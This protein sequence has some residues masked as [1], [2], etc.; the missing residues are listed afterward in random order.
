VAF[1]FN[2]GRFMTTR[3][4]LS[5]LSFQ[6]SSAGRQSVAGLLLLIA[7]IFVSADCAAGSDRV[8]SEH[9]GVFYEAFLGRKPSDS[10]SREVTAE[11]FRYN[12]AKGRGGAAIDDAARQFGSMAK[13][14]R[15]QKGRPAD[16]ALRHAYIQLNY[17]DPVV[18]NNP[19]SFRL[20]TEPDPV[21]VVAP[22]SK[23]L[24]TERDVVAWANLQYFSTSQDEP[25][26]RELSRQQVDDLV[27]SLD[28]AVGRHP[29]S[30]WMPP[31][32]TEAAALWAGIQREWLNLSAEQ[33]PQVRTYAAKGSFAPM[34]DYRL[35][36]KLLEL[37]DADA[38]QHKLRDDRTVLIDIQ[39]QGWIVNA[40]I[41][42]LRQ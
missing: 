10:E 27:I 17:F 9:L 28:R 15:E 30:G 29:R 11:F 21:R 20:L 23:Q 5:T 25:R 22:R 38:L 26:H 39:G 40:L 12:A 4:I 18:Q 34:G 16:F 8:V 31:S 2:Q 42:G 35:Y 6:R 19:T 1:F 7:M 24:M 13:V 41:N 37:S 33:K 36:G 3:R 14:L 32:H